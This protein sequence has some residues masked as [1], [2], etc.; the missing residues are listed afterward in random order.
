MIEA[1]SVFLPLP[2]PHWVEMLLDQFAQFPTAKHD[3]IVDSVTQGLNWMRD[4]E[5]MRQVTATWG[6]ADHQRQVLPP[7]EKRMIHGWTFT[8]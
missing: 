7:S 1:G 6:R 3:D 5:P 2:T 8:D 4:R